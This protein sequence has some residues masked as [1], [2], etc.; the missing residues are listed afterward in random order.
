MHTFRPNNSNP[1]VKKED[2]KQP[3]HENVSIM[4]NVEENKS[5]YL[6]LANRVVT[7]QSAFLEENNISGN[8][9]RPKK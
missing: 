6:D 9:S 1:S 2:V 3:K 5:Q 8:I 7:N 4:K